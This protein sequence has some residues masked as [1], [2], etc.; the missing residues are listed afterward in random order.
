M[1]TPPTIAQEEWA[2]LHHR[3]HL[4]LA[5]LTASTTPLS[6]CFVYMS[7]SLTRLLMSPGQGASLIFSK[8]LNNYFFFIKDFIY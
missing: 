2:V 1:A 7:V 4:V 8:V 3:L 5:S 6:T